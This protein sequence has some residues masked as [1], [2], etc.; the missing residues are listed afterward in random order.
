[1]DPSALTS[2]F[3]QRVADHQFSGVALVW[4]DGAPLYSY[5]GGLAH[6][7]H[8][9]PVTEATRFGVASV[10]KMVT[11][12]AVLRLVDRRLIA[13]HQPVQELLPVA[14]R[15]TAM[16]AEHTVHHLLSHTSGLADYSD[17]EDQ[18]WTSFTA[19][20]DRIPSYHLR[21]PADLL[22]LFADRP[23]AFPPGAMYQ[24]C[25]AN[26]VLLGLVLEALTGR[27][28]AEVAA[29]EVLGPAG[30]S[31]SSFEALDEEPPRLATGYLASAETPPQS[32]GSNVFSLTAAG[33]PDGGMITT[34]RD[35]VRLVE[36][37]LDGNLVSPASLAA[38]R[39]PQGP[40]RDG[41]DRYGYGLEL[42]VLDDEVIILGHGGSDPGVSARVSHDLRTATTIVV[43]CNLTRGS[44]VAAQQLEL[45][46][47]IVDPRS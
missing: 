43:L 24:Y 37:L 40:S 11:A 31:D 13:L 23:A 36:A 45:A 28:Y 3:D 42:V 29:D 39:I 47:G 8:G 35:L 38:M 44:W 21:R 25:D 18:S 16:T 46:L 27:P 22:P 5:A 34:A 26:Y 17:D 20:F 30:M 14:Q 32:W 10:T 19:I 15:P 33:M 4:R 9:V 12:T 41:V 6:R 2:W 1:M 7:G